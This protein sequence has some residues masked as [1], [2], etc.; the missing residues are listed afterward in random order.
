[1]KT[2]VSGPTV[3]PPVLI[4]PFVHS[5]PRRPHHIHS[6]RRVSTVRHEILLLID[7]SR[8][9]L[10]VKRLENS[11]LLQFSFFFVWF[12]S[13][14]CSFMYVLLLFSFH[15]SVFCYIFPLSFIVSSSSSFL[16]PSL[17]PL[18]FIYFVSFI[19]LILSEIPLSFFSFSPRLGISEV[20]SWTVL[21]WV[22]TGSSGRPLSTRWRTLGN[23]LSVWIIST[24]SVLWI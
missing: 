14:S 7:H 1:V 23:F 2:L 11:C 24:D 19:F 3:D 10:E 20:K 12:L 21:N 13:P 17:M 6:K 15:F 9:L 22:R 8:F 18:L 16:F 4:F 5:A